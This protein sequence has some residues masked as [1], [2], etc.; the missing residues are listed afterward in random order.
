[1]PMVIMLN[2]VALERAALKIEIRV[3]VPDS[4]KQASLLQPAPKARR[5]LE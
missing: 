3:K 4:N 1:M 2:V 5:C